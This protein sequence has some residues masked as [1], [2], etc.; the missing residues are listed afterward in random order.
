M[1]NNQNIQN[2]DFESACSNIVSFALEGE[3][4]PGQ[5]IFTSVE[6]ASETGSDEIRG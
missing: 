4:E 2:V 5:L 3:E 1:K 6:A